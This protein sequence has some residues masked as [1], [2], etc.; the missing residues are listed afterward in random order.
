M[1][2]G[3]EK[4]NTHKKLK[5]K[6]LE[7]AQV[8]DV[9]AIGPAAIFL[10]ATFDNYIKFASIG[11]GEDP[12]IFWENKASESISIPQVNGNFP[13]SLNIFATIALILISLPAS[14]AMVER[15]FSQL[16]AI[17]TDFNKSTAEGLFIALSVIKLCTRYKN[18]YSMNILK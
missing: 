4:T 11:A 5:D 6:F 7:I 9:Q 18:K 1:P 16:K 3:R 10:P 12:F 14:E 8:L 15:A 2:E 13:I 17:A